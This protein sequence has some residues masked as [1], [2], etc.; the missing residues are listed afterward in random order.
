M[1][2]GKR[3]E[4]EMLLDRIT[5]YNGLLCPGGAEKPSETK[6]DKPTRRT[7]HDAAEPAT[8][9]RSIDETDNLLTASTK[10]ESSS[11]VTGEWIFFALES[12]VFDCL[13][14]KR[15]AQPF[16]LLQFALKIT[17][18]RSRKVTRKKRRPTTRITWWPE[19]PWV[20]IWEEII[21][22]GSSGR[23][24]DSSSQSSSG[25]RAWCSFVYGW[26]SSVILKLCKKINTFFRVEFW[27]DLVDS[28][29]SEYWINCLSYRDDL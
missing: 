13:L 27:L 8:D 18:R 15:I 11:A 14:F 23:P 7:R 26:Y 1:A 29:Y 16:S 24:W 20:P 2:K 19:K 9:T 28:E 25:V 21:N 12:R 6:P 3:T 10:P 22:L 5:K 4:A 17:G